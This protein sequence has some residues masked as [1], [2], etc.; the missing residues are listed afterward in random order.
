MIC[1]SVYTYY[2]IIPNTD[3]I[4]GA[5]WETN[6]ILSK[7]LINICKKS[8]ENNGWKFNILNKEDSKKHLLYN[9]FLNKIKQYPTI[10]NIDYELACY[11]RWLAFDMCDGICI[12]YDIINISF[13]PLELNEST[14]FGGITP[15]YKCS[16]L[17]IKWIME[18]D[19]N[20]F[21]NHISDLLIY[22]YNIRNGNQNVKYYNISGDLYNDEKYY[23]KPLIHFS[24]SGV[25]KYGGTTRIKFI[26]DYLNKI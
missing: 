3:N 16:D 24:N 15:A 7:H 20:N 12:D 13:N 21:K 19:I 26:E 11:L 18:C 25:K 2:D 6:P 5:V 10:N 9:N 4:I 14:F 17:M 8:W 22:D 1:S 23:E